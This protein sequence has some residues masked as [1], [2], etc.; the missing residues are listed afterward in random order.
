MDF[1]FELNRSTVKKIAKSYHVCLMKFLG[2][3]KAIVQSSRT[4]FLGIA[5]ALSHLCYIKCRYSSNA[6]VA[7]SREDNCL[8]SDRFGIKEA[9]FRTL[10]LCLVVSLVEDVDSATDG[11]NG[12]ASSGCQRFSP[13]EFPAP[14]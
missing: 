1:G 9:S 5:T 3:L 14:Y 8:T 4:Y 6:F 12:L 2:F 10:V 7:L 13:T 11:V